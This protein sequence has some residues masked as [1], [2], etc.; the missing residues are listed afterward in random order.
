MTTKGLTKKYEGW[1]YVVQ[2]DNDEETVK[3]GFSTDLKGRFGDFLTYSA[4][5]LVVLK[6]FRGNQ[7]E[8]R[9]LHEKF[10]AAR[11]NGEWF[12]LSPSLSFFLKEQCRCDTKDAKKEFNNAHK[13]R[14]LWRPMTPA[15]Q[16]R[17]EVAHKSRKLPGFVNNARRY[18]LWAI[19]NLDERGYVCNA[20]AIINHPVNACLYEAKTIYNTLAF[21]QEEAL[22][23]KD[24]AKV[25]TLTDRGNKGIDL[26]QE[27]WL[28]RRYLRKSVRSLIP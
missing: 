19:K 22:I 13:D 12:V 4:H 26:L 28:E 24:E 15:A 18:I 11:G 17:L 27:Q 20:S 10:Q 21:L 23:A 14:V 5:N 7:D 9:L 1:I 8:E 3:I 2:W 6:A 25:Y 16:E